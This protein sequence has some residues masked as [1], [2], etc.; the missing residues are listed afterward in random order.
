MQEK[1]GEEEE[2]YTTSVVNI[3]L[4]YKPPHPMFPGLA[5]AASIDFRV[6]SE[7]D[8]LP[9]LDELRDADDRIDFVFVQPEIFDA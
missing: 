4:I 8:L 1:S 2:A 9:L 6:Y 3:R 7:E 5:G